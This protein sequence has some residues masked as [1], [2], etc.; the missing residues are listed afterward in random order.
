MP[1]YERIIVAGAPGSSKTHSWL[2]IAE[3][4]P[5]SMFYVFDPED[6]VERIRAASFPQVKNICYYFTPFWFRKLEQIGE[7][8]WFGGVSE[9]TSK[10]KQ[11]VKPNDWVIVE[12]LPSMW[13][14][15]QS[16]FVG[17]IWD[18]GIGEYF[19]ERR[20]TMENAGAK[21]KRLE[22]FD[23]WRDWGVIKKMHNDDF[24]IPICFQLPVHSYMTSS[25]SVTTMGEKEKEDPDIR[26]FYGDSLVRVDGE[27]R[28]V[29]RVQTIL[30]FY[31]NK[32][33]GWS[34]STFVKD[35]GNREWKDK[36]PLV[37]FAAQYL[38]GVAKM[39]GILG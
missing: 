1:S 38:G 3:A 39:P 28:N 4:L 13:D 22:A 25:L 8:R 7:R 20:K 10:I 12:S 21:S 29:F 6:G 2:T 30:I 34:Y 24:I 5:N 31:G 27:K 17:A 18:K 32:K 19:L 26:G 37:N 14:T 33:T 23:G 11:D 15:A 36:A 16:G 35:R 9:A